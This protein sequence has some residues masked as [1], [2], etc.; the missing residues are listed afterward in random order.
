MQGLKETYV[1]S[2][3]TIIDLSL[4]AEQTPYRDGAVC[5]RSAAHVGRARNSA[6][7]A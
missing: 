5:R 1:A 2:A 4:A 6:R 3:A 7:V